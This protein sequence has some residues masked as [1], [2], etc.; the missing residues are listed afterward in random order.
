MMRAPCSLMFAKTAV[1]LIEGSSA[2][3]SVATV[4]VAIR[5]S[6]RPV[7]ILSPPWHGCQIVGGGPQLRRR[8]RR[9]PVLRCRRA[10]LAFVLIQPDIGLL[11][12]LLQSHGIVG[13]EVGHADAHRQFVWATGA[14]AGGKIRLQTAADALRTASGFLHDQGHEFIAAQTRGHIES[15]KSLL[16]ARRSERYR[17]V[18]LTVTVA[19]VDPLQAVQIGE[20]HHHVLPRVAGPR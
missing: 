4:L 18:T 3:S 13:I 16:D 6:V 1:S 10:A 15:A 2:A 8:R 17:A 12:Q 7:C 9:S 11:H 19:V 5:G 14:A 20:E